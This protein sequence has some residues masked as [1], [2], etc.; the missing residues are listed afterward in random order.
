VSQIATSPVPHSVPE[1]LGVTAFDTDDEFSHIRVI[2]DV[3]RATHA[4]EIL[5][6][7]CPAKV[8]SIAPDG[9]ILTEWAACLECG[10]CLAAAPP[11]SLEWHYP[12]GGFGVRY[13]EG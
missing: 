5:V 9:S 10:T 2:Q 11:G 6:S 12:R 8:Y 3:A 4:A 7:I 1:R 13:R